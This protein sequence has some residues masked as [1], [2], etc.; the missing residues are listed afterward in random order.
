M[1]MTLH[2]YTAPHCETDSQWG[3]AAELLTGSDLTDE[4]AGSFFDDGGE[5]TF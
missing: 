5:F 4:G 3:L 2:K 1:L